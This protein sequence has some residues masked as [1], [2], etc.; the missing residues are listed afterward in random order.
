[1][2]WSAPETFYSLVIRGGRLPQLPGHE[3]WDPQDPVP[4]PPRHETWTSSGPT[5]TLLVKFGGNHWLP[6]QTC[7]LEETPS[8]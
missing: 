8:L 7:S 2:P 3:T 5:P 4:P 6:V 1:M